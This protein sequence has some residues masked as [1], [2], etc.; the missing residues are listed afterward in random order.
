MANTQERLL[1]IALAAG[2][3]TQ[4]SLTRA[5]KRR[6]ASHTSVRPRI[7]WPG[8]RSERRRIGYLLCCS[9]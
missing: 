1:D 7:L 9:V 2:F 3:D 8:I 5:F 6:L 4:E